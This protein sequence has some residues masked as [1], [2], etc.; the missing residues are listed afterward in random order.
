MIYDII[1]HQYTVDDHGNPGLVLRWHTQRS[2][3][4]DVRGSGCGGGGGGVDMSQDPEVFLR[5]M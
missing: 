1:Q 4:V 2:F 3:Y 5:Y